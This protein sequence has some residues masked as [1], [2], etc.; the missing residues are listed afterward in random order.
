MTQERQNG[1]MNGLV[2]STANG[3]S[4]RGVF[5]R[6]TGGPA[7]V[8]R[9]VAGVPAGV[10]RTRRGTFMVVV[11]GTLALLAVIA[12]AHFAIGQTDRRTSA[13]L[14]RSTR[15]DDIPEQFADYVSSV[16]TRDLFAVVHEDVNDLIPPSSNANSDYQKRLVERREADDRPSLDWRVRSNEVRETLSIGGVN[17]PNREYF[18]PWG[19]GTDPWLADHSPTWL[20]WNADATP[21]GTPEYALRRD[22]GKISA[23]SP[24]G[25]FVSLR[26]L[27]NN[28]AAEPGFGRAG[29][30]NRMSEE[31]SLLSWDVNNPDGQAQVSNQADFG[32]GTTAGGNAAGAAK[33]RPALWATRQRGA[34][35]AVKERTTV[36]PSAIGYADN[37][38]AD[39][40]LDGI[41]DARWFEL[42]DP[43]DAE[44]AKSFLDTDGR[45]RWFFATR[46]V[47]LSGMVNVNTAT[48]FEK[49]PGAAYPL[50]LNPG[51]I[52]LQR[53]LT[54]ADAYADWGVGYDGL[55]QPAGNPATPIAGNY[56]PY[57]RPIGFRLGTGAYDAIRWSNQATIVPERYEDVD[58]QWTGA[59]VAVGKEGVL[60]QTAWRG[61]AG[62][63]SGASAVFSGVNNVSDIRLPSIFPESDMGSLLARWS[64]ADPRETSRLEAATAARTGTGGR[65]GAGGLRQLGLDPLRSNRD[66]SIDAE[67][68]KRNQNANLVETGLTTRQALLHNAI[69]LR[70]QLTTMSWA[71]SIRSMSV[72]LSLGSEPSTDEL[73]PANDA[74]VP[75]APFTAIEEFGPNSSDPLRLEYTSEKSIFAGY[76]RAL[77][78]AL[79]LPGVWPQ[80]GVLPRG[81]GDDFQS[82]KT[83][84]YGHQGP[85]LALLVAGSMAANFETMLTDTGRLRNPRTLVFDGRL[86]REVLYR[87]GSSPRNSDNLP[88]APWLIG[89]S[90]YCLEPAQEGDP[91][92]PSLLSLD[93]NDTLQT[94]MLHLFG[95]EPQAF[96]TQ[97]GCYTVFRDAP[98]AGG[99]DPDF[100]SLGIPGEPPEPAFIT[101]NGDMTEENQ[102]YLFRCVAFQLHN[103]FNEAVQISQTP[104]SE[105]LL[106]STDK[107]HYVRIKN[108]DQDEEMSTLGLFDSN[109][110]ERGVSSRTLSGITIEPGQTIVCYVFNQETE[111]LATRLVDARFSAT[112]EDAKAFLT[113]WVEQQLRGDAADL[114]YRA[115][116]VVRL[117][118]NVAGATTDTFDPNNL[119]DDPLATRGTTVQLWRTLRASNAN[120]GANGDEGVQVNLTG[121]DRLMDRFRIPEGKSIDKRIAAGAKRVDGCPAGR[122][123]GPFNPDTNCNG[124]LTV[125]RWATVARPSDPQARNSFPVG[126]V[127]AYILEPQRAQANTLWHSYSFD[128]LGEQALPV[129]TSADIADLMADQSDQADIETGPWITRALTNTYSRSLTIAPPDLTANVGVSRIGD[130]IGGQSFD[131]IRDLMPRSSRLSK[132]LSTGN[133]RVFGT[134]LLSQDDKASTL[135]AA[136]MLLPM[137]IS[138]WESP[139]KPRAGANFVAQDDLDIRYLTAAE[140]FAVAYGYENFPVHG[141]GNAANPLALYRKTDAAPNADDGLG[142]TQER[143]V[144]V[145][146]RVVIEDFVPF[147]DGDRDGLFD[148][149][150]AYD[151]IRRN[152]AANSDIRF[153]LGIPAA[154]GVLDQFSAIETQFGSLFRPVP[155]RININTAPL[156]VLRT[157]PL[158]SPADPAWGNGLLWN[159]TWS[160]VDPTIDLAS[161]IASYRDKSRRGALQ[162]REEPARFDAD[163]AENKPFAAA[164]R[165]TAQ[166]QLGRAKAN[167]MDGIREEPGFVSVGELACVLNR[168]E[169]DRGQDPGSSDR[170]EKANIDAIGF[171]DLDRN[172]AAPGNDRAGINSLL[173]ENDRNRLVVDEV[174]NDFAERLQVLAA[175]SNVTTVRSDVFACWFVMRGY[176]Q[177]DVEGLGPDD[178]MAPSIERRFLMV[179][180]RSN[181]FKLGDGKPRI[182]VFKELFPDR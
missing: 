42:V 161:S 63:T 54:M 5:A 108:A 30:R 132:G 86:A 107:F 37:E 78:P 135:R 92:D 20:N 25:A 118:S 7:K 68:T 149:A 96:I 87:P 113:N 27:R 74:Q 76:V 95:F 16:I 120:Y 17:V 112:E 136:D 117:D 98:V 56:R 146:G 170:D 52:D 12:I 85:E 84:F 3:A 45:I 103:P 102:D 70:S 152:L 175:L 15:V 166:E 66:E 21:G 47:D 172:A 156:N 148:R 126:G 29:N 89:D 4:G 168:R 79:R 145:G 8:L 72:N 43:R 154:L 49:A 114:E 38:W 116:H 77:A 50:G 91:N 10:S 164:T 115:V 144:I 182:V 159:T 139:L 75:V 11:I 6:L 24:N 153:G 111:E 99:G 171:N 26:N 158:V 64:V 137:A 83:L 138:P 127:P 140:A 160:Q 128:T 19:D 165:V 67:R 181:V 80:S 100:R 41:Y 121:N 173:F 167:Q 150:Q 61:L 104:T 123:R 133:D 14:Q 44:I 163:A 73:L 109:E 97:V 105:A 177:Q 119:I 101:I 134:A 90:S 62:S 125:L 169:N 143:P 48:D 106:S 31:L 81:G 46:I 58:W 35:R 122:E 151:G 155:G 174:R 13:S 124:G 110:L 157:L 34:F 129:L 147:Y 69:D 2:N 82:R 51:D 180:D 178:P 9:A 53:L 93:T 59:G 162:G 1:L 88:A 23:I 179:I 32:L 39:T 71:R 142:D 141:V 60:R 55:V 65:G 18:T 57:T 131:Q 40:D 130:N 33:M 36:L 176:T 94:P 22:W 28:F